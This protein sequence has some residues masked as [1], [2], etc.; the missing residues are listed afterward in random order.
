MKKISEKTIQNITHRKE[1]RFRYRGK[2][3]IHIIGVDV[4]YKRDKIDFITYGKI[5]GGVL[6]SNPL[7]TTIFLELIN[8]IKDKKISEAVL[9]HEMNESKEQLR[10]RNSDLIRDKKASEH[11][12]EQ[13]KYC[14]ERVELINKELKA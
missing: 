1:L 7:P 10:R 4:M 5:E 14:T 3:E 13:I 8:S 12:R 9:K 11:D 2:K 6:W